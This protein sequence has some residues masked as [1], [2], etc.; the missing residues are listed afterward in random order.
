MSTSMDNTPQA[1]PEATEPTGVSRRGFLGGAGAAAAGLAAGS[2][3][4]GS[5]VDAQTA[6]A[7]PGGN[8][9]GNGNGGG[10][11][12]ARNNASWKVRKDA[13]DYWKQ[14]GS[15]SHPT[16]GDE[17]RYASRIGNYSKG[18]PHNSLGEVDPAAYNSLLTAIN[19]KSPSDYNAIILSPGGAK[20]G[21][22]QAGEGFDLYGLDAQAVAAPVPPA[23]ASREL[24]GE[25][26][27]HYWQALLRDVNFLDYNASPVAAAAAA[28]LNVFGA[29]FKGAKIGGVVTPQSL[30]R[31][32]SPGTSVGPYISQFMW[33]P[34]P[35]GAE[36]VERKTWTKLPVDHN[37][38]FSNF[39]AAR[40]GTPVEAPAFLG[41]RRY[42][43][44]GRD[45]AEW[46]H[47]D[48][49]FQAYFNAALI[50]GTPPDS[51]DTG[52]GI[53]TPLN[54]TN[55]YVGNPTQGA[56]ATWGPPWIMGLLCEVPR[57]ALK[58]TWHK[59]WQVHRRL[60]PEDYG[61]L[62]EVQLNQ[63]PG[64]YNGALHSSLFSSNVLDDIES[65]NGGTYLLPMAFPEGSPTHPSYTAGHATVAGACV[66]IIKALFNTQTSFIP[67]PVVPTPDGSA[68]VPYVGAPLTVE[69]E[70]NKL[71]SNV[72]NGRNIAGVHWRSDANASIRLGQAV[73]ISLLRDLKH[74]FNEGV[75]S[76]NFRGFDGEQIII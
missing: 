27:E 30:F 13:A 20:Q 21:S 40:N 54:P 34:T 37:T 15:A 10:G 25:M 22:P 76:F 5:L 6:E 55:P 41:D 58:A 63:S 1:P 12:V 24:A 14:Q 35:Y 26:V 50:M 42:I 32:P 74:T 33:L 61:G 59:K 2:V 65:H 73:A 56:F 4:L 52:G 17:E 19:S 67:N 69:G 31:D 11:G 47:I 66:T 8:G 71:A 53:G 36:F 28:D 48:V 51:S 60:R 75:A 45:L 64:R 29:D 9:N 72:A 38:T 44:N 3:T 62:V 70:L 16:N 39:L 68:L 23:L 46:V 49:L 43:V 18:L 57:N 7:A